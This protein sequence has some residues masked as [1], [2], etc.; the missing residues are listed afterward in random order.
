M[1]KINGDANIL[2]AKESAKKSI[3]RF[4]YVSTVENN[5]PD[6]VLKGYVYT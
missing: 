2:A 6:A 1:E 3:D 5:L 4:V